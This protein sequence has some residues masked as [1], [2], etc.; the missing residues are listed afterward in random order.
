MTIIS[1]TPG[2][3]GDPYARLVASLQVEF[4]NSEICALAARIREVEKAEF[5]RNSCVQQHYFG[6]HLLAD[7]GDDESGEE[8]ARIAILTFLAG[9]WH[10]GIC[11]VDRNGCAAPMPVQMR[12]KRSLG[13]ALCSIH[14]KLQE[15]RGRRRPGSTRPDWV[16]SSMALD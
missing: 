1:A 15:R 13:R 2:G 9:R 12:R 8:R 4:E 3:S 7:P 16:S 5:H 6:R 11:H 14:C 10:S